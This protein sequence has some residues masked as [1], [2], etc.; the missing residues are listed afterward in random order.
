MNRQ[1]KA[2]V[3]AL[4]AMALLGQAVA[5]SGVVVVT[6]NHMDGWTV[7]AIGTGNV[8]FVTGPGTPPVGKGS[9][10]LTIGANGDD[11]ASLRNRLYSGTKLTD[12]TALSYSTYVHSTPAVPGPNHCD[13]LTAFGGEQAVYVLLNIDNDNDG[14]A[15]DFI[16]FEPTYTAPFSCD[17]WNS[18]DT[19]AP[20]SKWWSASDPVF[21]PPGAPLAAYELAHPNATIV[22]SST[23]QGGV[24]L[25]S[26][27]GA[28]SWNNFIGNTDALTIGVA[29]KGTTTYDFEPAG[30][31]RKGDGD[32]D[33]DDK[34]GHKHRAHMHKN[35]CED[36]NGDV[37]E[38]DRDSGK[39]F[40]SSSV[41]SATFTSDVGSN[42][43]TMIGTGLDDGVP[44]GFTMV[45]VDYGGLT[46]SVFTLTLTDGRTF[47]GALVNGILSIE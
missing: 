43:L 11:H 18:W 38:D 33:F 20:T 19:L 32:G 13:P 47:T 34:D 22:N 4:A 12:L 44:V 3:A 29:G 17:T 6:P 8:T 25:S 1:A 10:Q 14:I 24:R 41:S 46:P 28:P 27:E 21:A 37:E 36:G 39:H 26:G 9:A 45:A 2:F 7:D 5:A 30:V 15:D 40:Q 42:T 16:F 23:G 31:C 35:S